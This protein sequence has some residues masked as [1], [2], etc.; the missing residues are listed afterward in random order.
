MSSVDVVASVLQELLPDLNEQFTAWHPMIERVVKGQR[1]ELAKGRYWEFRVVTGGPGR[2]VQISHGGVVIP[3]VRRQNYTKGR[4][5]ASRIIYPFDIPMLDVAEVSGNKDALRALI[6]TY[7][8]S[9]ISDVYEGISRQIARG[10][11]G[12]G[13]VADDAGYQGIVTLNGDQDYF[14]DGV[15][16]RDGVFQP[17]AAGSQTN[18]VFELGLSGAASPTTGW[19]HQYAHITAFPS[20]GREQMR[21]VYWAAGRKGNKF[22]EGIDLIIGDPAS[23]ANYLADLDEHVE[24]VEVKN[25]HVPGAIRKGVKFLDADFFAEEAIDISDTT[26][27]SSAA[28]QSGV[29]YFLCTK[30]WE[31]RRLGSD[32][33]METKGMFSMRGPTRVPDMDAYRWEIVNHWNFHCNELRKNGLVTGGAV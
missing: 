29:M 8:E 16:G 19:E 24:T 5:D 32:D 10:T 17:L 21:D 13:S 6:K 15:T 18:T 12:S 11:G 27:F 20:D 22:E 7:P 26:S 1:F 14:P 33:K 23:Y 9:A 4:Q 25:D 30:T 3:A 2:A 28:M 31:G